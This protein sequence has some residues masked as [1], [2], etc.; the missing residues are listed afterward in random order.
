MVD[1]HLSA[2]PACRHSGSE[3]HVVVARARRDHRVHLLPVVGAEVDHHRTVVDRVRLLDRGHDILGRVDAEAH[4]AH[5]L[6]PLHVVRQVRREV[7]LAVALLVEELLPLPH[8]AEV[9]VVQDRDLHRD[10]LGGRGHQ[11]LRGHLEAAVAV[12]GPHRLLRAADLGADRRGHREAHRAETTRVDP[13]VRV[14]EAPVLARPHLV[15]AHARR[16]DRVV[17]RVLAQLLDHELRLERTAF[18]LV[19]E[20]RVLGLPTLDRGAPVTRD[21]ATSRLA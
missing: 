13:R 16:Q 10:L 9:R 11:L 14:L 5:R 17:G 4:A 1:R 15:L 8:H 2:L 12:D 20:Q 3:D 21:R 6:G 18:G 19:V 7:H